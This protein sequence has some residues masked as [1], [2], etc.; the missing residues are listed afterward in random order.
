LEQS[1][2][3]LK[4]TKKGMILVQRETKVNGK[5][6]HVDQFIT[7][8]L[9]KIPANRNWGWTLAFKNFILEAFAPDLSRS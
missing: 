8:S 5:Y 1:R 6:A 4:L 3:T 2:V 7:E 9:T